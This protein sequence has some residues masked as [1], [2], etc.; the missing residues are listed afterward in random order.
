MSIPVIHF[1]TLPDLLADF[2]YAGATVRVSVSQ[3]TVT[4]T[5]QGFP[6]KTAT[7]AVCVTAMNSG[8]ILSYMPFAQAIKFSAM[9][10][11]DNPHERYDHAW[12]TAERIAEE[13][14]AAIR[15]AGHEPYPGRF[16]LFD[17][18]PVQGEAWKPQEE[19]PA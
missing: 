14:R 16:D 15:L 9:T 7:V 12:R 5:T 11:H 1:S 4:R 10:I 18:E 13:V 17:A 2:G 6:S 3:R 8:C 19:L